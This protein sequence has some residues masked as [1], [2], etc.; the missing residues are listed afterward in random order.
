ML[1]EPQVPEKYHTIAPQ[2]MIV[3]V[4]EYIPGL[5]GRVTEL[6]GSYYHR[7]WGFDLFFE[8]KV[9]SELAD[10]LE[11]FN[12][13]RDGLWIALTDDHHIVGSIAV[14]GRDAGTIGAR[15]RWLIVDPIHQN[16]GLGKKLIKEAMDFCGKAGFRRIYLTTFSGLDAARSLYEREGFRMISQ[17]QDSHWGKRVLEQTFEK[18]MDGPS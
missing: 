14:S 2:K 5:L 12:P 10:F 4:S 3:S 11:H 16:R 9:A 6:H 18:R 13:A 17:E 7:N 15:L 1:A 8:N